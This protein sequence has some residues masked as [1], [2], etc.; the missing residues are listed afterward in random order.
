M[1]GV[2]SRTTSSPDRPF[3]RGDL[4]CS[5][6]SVCRRSFVLG[7]TIR[8]AHIWGESKRS[9]R[10]CASEAG[11]Q[12]YEDQLRGDGIAASQEDYTT[13][14]RG[15][16]G[17]GDPSAVSCSYWAKVHFTLNQHTR[18]A[19][20]PGAGLGY[21][22]Q[23]ATRKPRRAMRWG[24]NGLV[25]VGISAAVRAACGFSVVSLPESA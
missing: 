22:Q 14:G 11:K 20:S 18:A 19:T 6:R 17:G 1:R 12:W 9:G 13:R 15:W 7:K 10:S 24:L 3:W 5:V 16:P 23:L 4:T 25:C 8:V 2:V 21:S